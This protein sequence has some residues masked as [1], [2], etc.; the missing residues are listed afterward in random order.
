[1]TKR[2]AIIGAGPAGYPAA[3]KAAA[4]GAQV[5][6]IEKGHAGGVCLNCGC[7]PSKSLLDAAH[8]FDGVK[9]LAALSSSPEKAQE[10]FNTF[11]FAKI[12]TRRQGVTDRLKRGLVSLFKAAKINYIEGSASFVSDKELTVNGQ[13]I[14]FDDVIIAT[15]TTAFYPAPFDKYKDKLFDNSNI[16]TLQSVPARL[17]IIGGGV[18][19]CEFACIFNALG[20]K[21]TIVEMLPSIVAVEDEDSIRVLKTSFEKRGIKL[22][23]GRCAKDIK[24]EGNLK[25]ISLDDGSIVESEEVLV[26]VGR[27]VDLTELKPEAA[28]ITWTR[29]GITVDPKTLKVKDNI[30]AT[31]D[32]NGLCL[33]AHAAGA[34]G[35]VA[36]ELIMGHDAA[37]DNDLIPKAIYTWPEVASVGL[38]RKEAAAKGIEVKAHKF[39]MLANGRA[40]TQDEGEGFT[41]ILSDAKTGKIVGAQIVGPSAAELI[42]IP[43][44]AIHAGMTAI[45]LAK[46][47]FA[48]P[49]VSETIKDAVNK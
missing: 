26:A 4:L 10:F 42:H 16:F 15:G 49:T 6:L 13:S 28:G 7:I 32:V 29:K 36:A 12:Q 5:T 41:Q 44:L 2:I 18:I 9:K 45:R 46:I 8:K 48:H 25:Q 33:L 17:T 3:L 11:D 38:N 20:S 40:L 21:V 35:E 31:G 43:L 39:F 30:Y 34:Q 1:M 37:Y 14:T 22:L 19:G 47:V 27:S 24:F 23:T